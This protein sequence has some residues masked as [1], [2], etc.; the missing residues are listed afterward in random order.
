[1][2][3]GNAE[4]RKGWSLYR[5]NDSDFAK[6]LVRGLFPGRGV[7]VQSNCKHPVVRD[8]GRRFSRL[9]VPLECGGACVALRDAVC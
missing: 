7:A 8:L 1:M 3:C 5:N 6:S 2:T 4:R 9:A